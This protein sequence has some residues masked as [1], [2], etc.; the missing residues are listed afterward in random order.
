MQFIVPYREGSS[1][2]FPKKKFNDTQIDY[3]EISVK[4]LKGV[5]IYPCVYS[6][7]PVNT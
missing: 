5:K 7:L 6:F 1:F 3:D 4:V 2:N